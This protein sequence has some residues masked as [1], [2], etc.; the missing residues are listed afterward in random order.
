MSLT[1]SGGGGDD[2]D[3]LDVSIVVPVL[4]GARTMPALLRNLL[5][6][7]GAPDRREILVVDNGSIDGGRGLARATPG[8]TLLEAPQRGVS[9]A[10]NVGLRA[11]RGRIV[12]C[13]DVD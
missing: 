9:A 12:A 13:V 8:I 1:R 11:A 3:A 6:Q 10:R 7:V 5:T 2:V 4:D